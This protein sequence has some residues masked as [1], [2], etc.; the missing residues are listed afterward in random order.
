MREARKNLKRNRKK[1]K[2]EERKRS[3]W[4]KKGKTDR[5]RELA[6]P[7]KNNLNQGTHNPGI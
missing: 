5:D 1:K 7:L 3:V 4:E 6:F 2:E